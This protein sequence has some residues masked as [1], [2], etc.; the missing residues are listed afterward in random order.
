ML[1]PG[2][3]ERRRCI[4]GGRLANSWLVSRQSNQRHSNEKWLRPLDRERAR[5]FDSGDS[6]LGENPAIS[7][8]MKNPVPRRTKGRAPPGYMVAYHS[9]TET[10]NYR[11]IFL[12]WR[13]KRQ[14]F[15]PGKTLGIVVLDKSVTRERKTGGWSR[16]NH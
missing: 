10:S 1:N 16:A 2:Q 7:L 13:W 9:T 3:G 15:G 6:V 4:P 5:F 8:E 14:G 11:E 12:G